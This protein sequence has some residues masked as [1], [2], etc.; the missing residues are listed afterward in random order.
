MNCTKIEV[1]S[2]HYGRL[3]MDLTWSL[4]VSE[5]FESYFHTSSSSLTEYQ[6]VQNLWPT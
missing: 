1:S 6:V 4:K 5:N 2:D 3:Q